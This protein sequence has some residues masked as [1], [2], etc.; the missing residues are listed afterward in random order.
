MRPQTGA[1]DL[2]ASLDGSY[3]ACADRG[4]ALYATAS[5][6]QVAS[7][8]LDGPAEVAFLGDQLL[9]VVPG[10]GRTQLHGF[11]VP[12]LEL[13]ASLELEGRLRL[14]AAVGNRALVVTEGLEQP[15]I[16]VLTTKIF[17]ETI[18][19]REPLLLAT[20]A[21]EDR[22][23]VA[24]RGRDA[25]LEC[26]DPFLRRA[27]FRLNLPLMPRAHLAGFSARRR[28]LWIAGAGPQG[29]LE[30]FRFSDGRLQARVE[31]GVTIV[32]ASGHPD[33]PRLVVATSQADEGVVSLT[34]L[35]FQLGERRVIKAPFSP[36][37]I[38]VV[39]G[40]QPALVLVDVGPPTWLPLD[41]AAASPEPTAAAAGVS[42]PRA[43]KEPHPRV[44]NPADWRGKLQAS[45]STRGGAATA[46][47]ARPGAA[48]SPRGAA[49]AVA[50]VEAIDTLD[51]PGGH[52]RDELCDWA[53]KQLA[54]PRRALEA[55]APP[56]ESTLATTVARLAL[57]ERSTRALQLLYGARLLGQPGVPAAT[58]AR[59][60]GEG[61]SADEAAW[62]EALGRGLLGQLGLARAREGRLALSRPTGRFLDGAPP[63][64]TILAGAASD[65]ELPIGNVRLDGGAEPLAE[66]GAR[67]A[68]QYGY[69]V[70]L[71][72][73]EGARPARSLAAMLVE[74]RLHGAWPIVDVSVKA[75]RWA[76]ALDEGPTVVVVRGDEVPAAIAA[77]PA[78]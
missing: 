65:A 9:V 64:L 28:L 78:L 46:A 31:L 67:L 48:S 49:A 45:K 23:L 52:W 7:A 60:L 72:L 68:A 55:P 59:A 24:S 2:A 74:A 26:W 8:A 58:V 62:D 35:D 15:R 33:S 70:A 73:V 37:A 56:E 10:D 39:E 42:T 11:S 18:A 54:S 1:P 16:V 17:V 6:T 38:C 4:L 57:D 22:L 25:Q 32:G 53:D 63:R 14:L 76:S 51:E 21:P 19:L 44:S 12:S 71:V 3:V 36:K 50:A 61:E 34:E 43:A 20:A 30:V 41:V 5:R 40:A 69:D 77:L 13:I 29:T 66:I 47:A 75:A 27:L